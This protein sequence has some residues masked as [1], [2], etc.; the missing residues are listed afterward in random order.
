MPDFSSY[1]SFPRGQL[2]TSGYSGVATFCRES[3]QTRPS[4]AE[5]SLFL[6]SE[7]IFIKRNKSFEFDELDEEHQFAQRW[8]EIFNQQSKIGLQPSQLGVNMWKLVDGEG[9]CLVTKHEFHIE[10]CQSSKYLFVFN[11]YCPR[12]DQTRPERQHFQ[13]RFYHLLQKRAFQLLKY[14]Q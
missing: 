11:F 4:A 3:S 1:F 13:L 9:R 2:Q 7:E 6:D 12:N 14:N 8:P 5:I 10:G